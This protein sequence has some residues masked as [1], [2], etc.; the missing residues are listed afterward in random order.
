MKTT[1]NKKTKYSSFELL[2]ATKRASWNSKR[3]YSV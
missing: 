1:K 3:R 2:K